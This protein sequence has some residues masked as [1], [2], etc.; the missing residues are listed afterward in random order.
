[1]NLII[2]YTRGSGDRF[3]GRGLSRYPGGSGYSH[4][5]GSGINNMATGPV[6]FGRNTQ[7]GLHYTLIRKKIINNEYCNR[8]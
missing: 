2:F 3:S 6:F 7:V 5:Q 8:P 1:M 4:D